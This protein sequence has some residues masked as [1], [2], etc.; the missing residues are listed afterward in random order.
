VKLKG[1]EPEDLI[2][3]LYPTKLK[4]EGE[5]ALRTVC[6]DRTALA[7][8]GTPTCVTWMDIK[9]LMYGGKSLDDHVFKLGQDGK[10]IAVEILALKMRFERES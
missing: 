6:Q 8:T 1:I 4:T 9:S 5:V 7:D 2:F 3:R 10:A